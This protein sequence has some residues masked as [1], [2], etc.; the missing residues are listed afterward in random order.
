MSQMPFWFGF[1][2]HMWKQEKEK[3]EEFERNMEFNR[4]IGDIEENNIEEDSED[5]YDEILKI[6]GDNNYVGDNDYKDGF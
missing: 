2:Y 6:F 5:S 4:G 3:N 1:G